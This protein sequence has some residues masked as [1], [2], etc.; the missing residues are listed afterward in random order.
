MPS[1][2]V[3]FYGLHSTYGPQYFN[4][5]NLGDIYLIKEFKIVCTF[6]FNYVK[7]NS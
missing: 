6:I 7:I 1:A 5:G 2:T 3:K 4:T